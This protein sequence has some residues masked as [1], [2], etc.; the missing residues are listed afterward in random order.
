[1][2][3]SIRDPYAASGEYRKAQLHCHTTE[4]DGRLTPHELLEQYRAAGYSFVC[5]TDHNRVTRYTRLDSATFVTIP[6]TEDTVSRWIKPL[7]PHMSRLFVRSSLTSGT[8]QERIEQ[9]NT[10][11]GIV[12]L[13]HPSWNG[14]LWTGAWSPEA[15][16]NLRSYHL[17]EIWNP[18]SNSDED[19]RRW[20]VALTTLGPNHPV[21]GAAVDDCHKQHQ[22]NKA[23]VMVKVTM[24]SA[25]A[26][27]ASLKRGAFY[28]STGL[29]IECGSRAGT[30]SVR[31]PEPAAIRFLDAARRALTEISDTS[32][33]YEVR[34]NE[35]YVRI[36]CGSGGRRA[37]SQPFWIIGE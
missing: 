27:R 9:T 35:G 17:F 23:W 24:V 3:F 14:N 13:C 31:L 28:S 7:G 26:L 20:D 8:A 29:E 34:G 4:S 6:A 2:P 25:D 12:G 15:I 32:A 22:F 36:E 16:S 10:E 19:L 18:H 37:W 1:M 21:W 33:T 30:I 11:Q 5:I